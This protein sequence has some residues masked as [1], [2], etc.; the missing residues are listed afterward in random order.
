MKHKNFVIGLPV[1]NGEKFIKH[2]IDSI[3]SQSYKNFKLI[4]SDN[5]SEDNTK[6]ICKEYASKDKRVSYIRHS[7][8]FGPHF[9]FKFLLD[10]AKS[11]YFM[12]A[13]ADDIWLPN[14]LNSCVKSLD[15]D[16]K[17]NYAMTDFIVVSRFSSI[18]NMVFTNGISFIENKDREQ[19][20]LAY[21]KKKFDT[22]IDNLFYSVWRREFLQKILVELGDIYFSKYPSIHVVQSALYKSHG[23]FIPYKFFL[24][25]YSKF[26]PGHFFSNMIA[27]IKS[28]FSKKKQTYSVL[29]KNSKITLQKS[30]VEKKIILKFISNMKKI[31]IPQ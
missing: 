5:C 28:Y 16:K 22:Y 15:N 18:F 9:N 14:F 17:A 6:N 3:L 2:A 27:K 20:L 11:K 1:Y 25:T 4:I 21:S 12:W 8:N 24:K 29:I 26:P 13:A 31:Q 30:G 19:R 10:Q 7:K 23:K